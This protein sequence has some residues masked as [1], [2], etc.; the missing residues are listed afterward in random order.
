MQADQSS[1]I[2]Q[3]MINFIKQHGDERVQDIE[4]NTKEQFGVE[5]EKRIDAEKKKIEE[6]FT[7]MLKKEEV[8]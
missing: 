8:S 6:N 3:S 4:K 2:L 5:K 1:H 7:V